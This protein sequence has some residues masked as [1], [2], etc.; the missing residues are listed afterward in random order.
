[1]SADRDLTSTKWRTSS[2]STSA[3]GD[4]VEVGTGIPGTVPVR[5]SKDP[6]GA[7]LRFSPSPWAAFVGG[8]R[9]GALG[10]EQDPGV[11]AQ[12]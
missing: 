9:Q 7:V 8:L 1:M 3:G 12:G 10:E 2:R 4:C 6:Q 5:D 11:G